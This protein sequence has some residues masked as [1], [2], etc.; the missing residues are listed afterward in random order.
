MLKSFDKENQG[1]TN[2]NGL[3]EEVS[4]GECSYCTSQDVARQVFISGSGVLSLDWGYKTPDHNWG[5]C[6][7]AAFRQF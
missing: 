3:S 6:R 2:P 5:G 7:V 4:D 1:D